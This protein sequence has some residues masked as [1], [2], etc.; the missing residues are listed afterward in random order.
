MAQDAVGLVEYVWLDLWNRRAIDELMDLI[1]P[2]FVQHD[3]RP[4]NMSG[5]SRDALRELWQG[6]WTLVPDTQCTEVV[7][8]A[9]TPDVVAHTLRFEGTDSISGGHTESLL[10][11]VTRLAGGRFCEADLFDD[12]DEA[13]AH[14]K[15]LL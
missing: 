8:I 6:W 9:A 3:H 4:F 2:A 10:S 14:F 12:A 13:A 15:A 1:D 11:I 7:V 5:T